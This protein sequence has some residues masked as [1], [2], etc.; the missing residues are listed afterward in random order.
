MGK[1]IKKHDWNEYDI[2]ARGNHITEKINGHLMCEVTDEDTKARKDGIIALQI[3][4]GQPMK[5]QFRN[6]RLKEFKEEKTTS[7][8]VKK[9]IVF[10]A[11]G[12]SHGYAQHEHHAGCLLLAK[13]INENVP[14]AESVVIQGWPS[15][16]SVL[17]GAASI[18]IYCDGG[19]GHLS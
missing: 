19:E 16:P 10:I 1:F 9:K 2:T 6:V 7:S 11:G 4:A 15:D 14:E 13:C 3:H 18:V 5:V 17:D 12:P 8:E